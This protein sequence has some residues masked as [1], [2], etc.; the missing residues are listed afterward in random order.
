MNEQVLGLLNTLAAKL[1]TS[2]DKLWSILVAGQH[3][4]GIANMGL[5]IFGILIVCFG[6][7]MFR[8]AVADGWDTPGFV[9]GGIVAFTVGTLLIFPQ[10]YDAIIQLYA[11]EY[12][13][14]KMIL[15]ALGGQ[16]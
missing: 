8:L 12:A 2:V 14:L 4:E 11:P 6:V 10:G 1:G 16:H 5:A 7:W 13:A 3:A 15:K 9:V